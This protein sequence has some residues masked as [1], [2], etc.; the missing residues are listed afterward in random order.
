M[1]RSKDSTWDSKLTPNVAHD[2]NCNNRSAGSAL[3][4][5]TNFGTMP[6]SCCLLK[7]K[8]FLP[9]NTGFFF[10]KG[11]HTVAFQTMLLETIGALLRQSLFFWAVRV[12]MCVC[13]SQFKITDGDTEPLPV[14]NVA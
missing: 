4:C 12:Y 7:K 8:I 3:Q 11:V 5:Q 13:I 2:S 1:S 10:F 6:N 14:Y 9:F